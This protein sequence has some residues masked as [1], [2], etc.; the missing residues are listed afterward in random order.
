MMIDSTNKTAWEGTMNLK[1]EII[2][3]GFGGDSRADQFEQ[4]ST[5]AERFDCKVV[6]FTE[7]GFGGEFRISYWGSKENLDRLLEEIGYDEESTDMKWVIFG[8]AYVL[9]G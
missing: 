5:Q 8:S 6:H 7:A 2:D 4:A 3:V 9:N 1:T